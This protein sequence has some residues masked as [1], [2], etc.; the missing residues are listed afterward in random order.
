MLLSV[1]TRKGK[2]LKAQLSP[3]ESQVL[4]ERT[5]IS[6]GSSLRVQSPGPANLSS[7]REPG[8]QPTWPSGSPGSSGRTR[9]PR[10]RQAAAIRLQR[11]GW[12]GSLPWPQGLD[13]A[14]RWTWRGLGKPCRAQPWAC[15]LGHSSPTGPRPC[16]SESQ[17]EGRDP[18]L[19][20]V[21]SSG[22][23]LHWPLIDCRLT[24]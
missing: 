1:L 19:T 20:F 6:A 5:Q 9:R 11:R 12:Q 4:A 14:S 13:P 18:S 24:H 16:K 22:L 10:P 7:P 2:A 3:S 8:A 21:S 17:G 23:Q 15:S